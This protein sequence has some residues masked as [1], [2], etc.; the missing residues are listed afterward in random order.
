L[1]ENE[2]KEAAIIA[3]YLPKQMT[4]AELI[5]ALKA[6]IQRVGATSPKDMGRVIG[7]AS[8]ELAGKADGKMIAEKAKELLSAL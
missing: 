3:E 6:I 1:Y 2:V 4:E 8:K 7:A 5:P